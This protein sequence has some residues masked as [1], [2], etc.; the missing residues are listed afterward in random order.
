[1]EKL[2]E[3]IPR[4]VF[5]VI[6]IALS[7]VLF[8]D[9]RRLVIADRTIEDLKLVAINADARS[10]SSEEFA[11]KDIAEQS[12][13]LKESNRVAKQSIDFLRSQLRSG[14]SRLSIATTGCIS[15]STDTTSDQRNQQARAEL[16][17]QVADDLVSIAADGDIAI[18]ALNAC[19]DSYNSVRNIINSQQD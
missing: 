8:V 14:A 15:A 11:K 7:S 3:L 17:S 18:R 6:V 2:L 1:M 5:F 4:S 19:I 13:K 10:R 12:Q 16:D 9:H